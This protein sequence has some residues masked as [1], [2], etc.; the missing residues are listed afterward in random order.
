[1]PQ[2]HRVVQEIAVPSTVFA[3][4]DYGQ[5]QVMGGPLLSTGMHGRHRICLKDILYLVYKP[6]AHKHGMFYSIVLTFDTCHF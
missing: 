5:Q 2:K 6:G 1:M 4:N 3:D